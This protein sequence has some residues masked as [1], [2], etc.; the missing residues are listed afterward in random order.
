MTHN[1]A[2]NNAYKIFAKLPLHFVP[3]HNTI[4]CSKPLSSSMLA[5][6]IPPITIKIIKLPDQIP[7]AVLTGAAPKI[8]YKTGSNK[9]TSI[10]GTS[11]KAAK[12]S[13]N[14]V[15]TKKAR[16]SKVNT[17]FTGIK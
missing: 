12:D 5:K 17:S 10:L 9:P 1:P 11:S 16:I 14:T 7:K 3:A 15:A 2:I 13:E 8:T 4:R 6:I